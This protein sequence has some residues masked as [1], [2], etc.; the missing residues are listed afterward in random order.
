M[1]FIQF[2]F[3]RALELIVRKVIFTSAAFGEN[4]FNFLA[5]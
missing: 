5:K 3:K 4:C 1:I 2:A